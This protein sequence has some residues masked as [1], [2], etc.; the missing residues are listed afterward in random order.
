MKRQ[1]FFEKRQMRDDLLIAAL[2][3]LRLPKPPKILMEKS[4]SKL[5]IQTLTFG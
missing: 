2:G 4:Y 1:A 3:G 5:K